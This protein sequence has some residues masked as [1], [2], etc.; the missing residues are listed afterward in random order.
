MIV[1]EASDSE[2]EKIVRL[3]RICFPGVYSYSPENL[4]KFISEGVLLLAESSGKILGYIAGEVEE[5]SRIASICVHPD[6]RGRGIGRTLLKEFEK[7]V[8]KGII[9]IECNTNNPALL[10]FLKNGFRAF[11]MASLYYELPFNSSRDAFLMAKLV[12]E[13]P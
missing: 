1:R 9:L 2:L 8:K 12:L 4:M 5:I 11:G 3:E 10:F 6:F 13:L 7:R